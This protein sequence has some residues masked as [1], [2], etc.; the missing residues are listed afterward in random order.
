MENRQPNVN[1]A[2]SEDKQENWVNIKK[3]TPFGQTPASRLLHST[4][5]P[6]LHPDDLPR[7]QSLLKKWLHVSRVSPLF[8]YSPTC[9][10]MYSQMLSAHLQ[11]EQRKGVPVEMGEHHTGH[12]LLSIFPGLAVT[13][14]ESEAVCIQVFKKES[15]TKQK[16][17]WEGVLC[18]TDADVSL[19]AS[20]PAEF[21][22]LPLMLWYGPKG[23]GMQ[24]AGWL[25]KTF[26]CR[27]GTLT[28][29]SQD[30]AWMVTLWIMNEGKATNCTELKWTA[31]TEEV[32]NFMN[33][34]ESHFYNHFHIIL[35]AMSLAYIGTSA[36]CAAR[37]GK[38]KMLTVGR[39]HEVLRF[40]TELAVPH[41][42]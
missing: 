1:F 9:L 18:C 31:P 19:L 4:N 3:P 27:V 21:T 14:K 35:S 11:A 7:L 39:M 20:I 17:V 28:L 36:A 34:I 22:C 6:R 32:S 25:Q 15:K 5:K 16:I 23:V 2:T 29:T 40:L 26:D 38:I 8:G 33:G 42:Q 41:G 37:K 12:A 24:V 30:L 13:G 10:K